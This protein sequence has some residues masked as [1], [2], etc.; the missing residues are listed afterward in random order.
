MP[1]YYGRS[2]VSISNR[3]NGAMGEH[4]RHDTDGMRLEIDAPGCRS[5]VRKSTEPNCPQAGQ[6]N[7]S[8]GSPAAM[9]APMVG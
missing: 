7:G 9:A 3:A 6:E 8:H 4:G 1:Q 5:S 2:A